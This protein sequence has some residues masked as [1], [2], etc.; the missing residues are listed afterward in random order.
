MANYYFAIF[1]FQIVENNSCVCYV[2]HHRRGIR[3]R[4]LNAYFM[5]AFFSGNPFIHLA[6]RWKLL[7]RIKIYELISL[8]S[9]KKKLISFDTKGL[10]YLISNKFIMEQ[11][12]FTQKMLSI[13]ITFSLFFIFIFSFSLNATNVH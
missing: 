7:F 2:L 11:I 9:E 1:H 10:I 8:Q 4:W 12:G 5:N 13:T 3:I 6:I